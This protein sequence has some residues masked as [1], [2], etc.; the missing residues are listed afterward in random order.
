MSEALKYILYELPVNRVV[1][2]SDGDPDDMHREYVNTYGA[3]AEYRKAG[4]RVDCVHI[5]TGTAGEQCLR[6]IAETTGGVYIKFEDITSFSKAFKF[7]TPGFYGQLTAGNI[8]A[9]QMG[10]KEVK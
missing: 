2:V 9:E 7:L 1:L 10:A 6:H 5:G 3:A 8:T 4:I